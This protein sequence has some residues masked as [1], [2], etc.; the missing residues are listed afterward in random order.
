[1]SGPTAE[2][3]GN[4]GALAPAALIVGCG[5]LGRRLAERLVARGCTVY[6]TTRDPDKGRALAELGVKPLIVHITQP[7]TLSALRPALA[8]PALDVYHMIPPG[9]GGQG[10]SP[11]Q[12]VLGG[13]GHM[14]KALRDAA[15]RRALLVSSSAVY[16]CQ[17]GRAVDADTR[18]MPIDDR[19]SLLLEGEQLWRDAGQAF[20]VVRLAGLYG[21][22]RVV[23]L[24]AVR[25]GAPLVGK[26]RALLNLIHVEDAAALL[27]AAMRTA[28]P[29]PV[30]LGADGHPVERITYYTEL[31][32]RVGAA[33]PD[34][35][36]DAD[37]ATQFG[38]SVER[39]QRSPSKALDPTPTQQRTGWA[40]RY[41][42]YQAGLD[43]VLS[44]ESS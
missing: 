18:P 42:D 32:R 14:T 7:L 6:G 34:V 35:L 5:D 19:G 40:P 25:D 10:P 13:I 31:A 4:E 37:A 36:D 24:R 11:R 43:A 9:R 12:V 38:V 29:G 41:P 16:G 8:E 27:E 39:L 3:S 44:Q 23:G 22:D 15:V 1:M 28:Q 21:P 26:A 30:E 20:H 17:D 2:P 33:P